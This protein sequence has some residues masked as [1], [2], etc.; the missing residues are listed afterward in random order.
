MERASAAAL[1]VRLDMCVG[2]QT[3]ACMPAP[4]AGLF[5]WRGS[6]AVPRLAITGSTWSHSQERQQAHD[7]P[8]T[9]AHH[10][11]RLNA[12]YVH[13]PDGDII[14]AVKHVVLPCTCARVMEK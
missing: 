3:A 4:D 14:Q 2:S 11:H 6:E 10:R 1:G 12:T 8:C 13:D 5:G 9:R 7:S